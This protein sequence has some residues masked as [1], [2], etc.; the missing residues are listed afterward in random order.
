MGVFNW[1]PDEDKKESV[2][3]SHWWIF[4][5]IAGGL[6]VIVLGLYCFWTPLVKRIRGDKDAHHIA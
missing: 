5:P 2:L 3:S 6:T 4:F 1:H